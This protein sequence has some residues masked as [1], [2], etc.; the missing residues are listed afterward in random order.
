MS[1]N[2]ASELAEA[3]LSR[4]GANHHL[5]GR[6]LAA[7]CNSALRVPV[8]ARFSEVQLDALRSK[9]REARTQFIRSSRPIGV[10]VASIAFEAI[11]L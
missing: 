5:L 1:Q 4:F 3:T 7:L 8:K 6:L 9:A 2:R 10:S 11:P